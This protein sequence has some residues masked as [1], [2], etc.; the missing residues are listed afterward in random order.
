MPLRTLPAPAKTAGRR[1]PAKLALALAALV[2]T[3]LAVEVGARILLPREIF[4]FEPVYT[5]D[6]MAGYR[7]KPNLS[8]YAF[9]AQ[10]DTNSLGCRG[11]EWPK[12][13]PSGTW[14]IVLIG[15]SI[16]FGFGVEFA[17]TVGELLAKMV[18]D[19]TNVPCEVLNFG[20]PGYNSVQELAV[21]ETQALDFRPD[22]VLVMVSSNDHQDRLWVDPEGFLHWG[23]TGQAHTRV[24]SEQVPR[25]DRWGVLRHS[26]FLTWVKILW[27]RH[28]ARELAY[29]QRAAKEPE[30]WMGPFAPGPVPPELAAKVLEPLLAMHEL[31]LGQGAPMVLATFASPVGYRRLAGEWTR[32]AGRPSLEL[33]SLFPDVNSWEAMVEAYGLGWDPHPNAEAYRRCAR[34]LLELF[35]KH[36]LL[37]K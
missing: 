22:L 16:A 13:K 5:T 24:E 7:F 14:R 31:C 21:L 34:G 15:D 4:S 32:R 29:H 8:V 10:L 18:T 9:G 28:K 20:V 19:Q 2:A 3:G 26:A 23:E 11:H 12:E 33:L 6:T 30:K 36:G 17:D 27:T 25:Q 1:L 37:P 35:G